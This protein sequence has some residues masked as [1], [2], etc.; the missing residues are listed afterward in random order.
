MTQN[1]LGALYWGKNDF[2][3]AEAAFLEAL[4]IYKRL[5]KGNP[6][7]YE[8][9]VAG[10]QNNIGALYWGKNDFTEA[11]AAFLEALEIYKRLA[12]GNQQTYEPDVEG[13]KNNLCK[14]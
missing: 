9:D 6:Q 14:V 10:I 13:I 12:K 2:T 3:K 1:N 7:T 8:L 11:E 4:E 5:A